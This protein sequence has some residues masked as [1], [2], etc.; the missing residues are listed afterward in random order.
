MEEKNVDQI[1]T[2]F[3]SPTG[4]EV[5]GVTPLREAM[6]R[7]L[8]GTALCA[9]TLNFLMLNYIL[10]I[11][12]VVLLLQ[13]LRGLRGENKWFRV[14]WALMVFRAAV[15]FWSILLYATIYGNLLDGSPVSIAINLFGFAVQFLMIIYIRKGVG[16][17]Q[18]KV[19]MP[20]Q[21][22]SITALLVWYFVF[23]CLALVEYSGWF[24][25]LVMFGTFI[26]IMRSLYRLTEEMEQSKYDIHVQ[27]ASVFDKKIKKWI[28]VALVGAIALGYIFLGSYP[29]D[30]QKA[31]GVLS[32][33][34]EEIK[35]DLLALGYPENALKDLSEEDILACKGAKS[36]VYTTRVEPVNEGRK[37]EEREGTSVSSR[38]VYDE[39]ELNFTDVAVELPDEV[40]QYRIFH[41]FLWMVDPGFNGTEALEIWPAYQNEEGWA[42]RGELTGRVLFNEKGT[43][44]VAPFYT[45]TE[46]SEHR[47]DVFLGV[48]SNRSI[49]ASFSLP[50]GVEMQRGY[51]SYGIETMEEGYMVS[52]WVNYTHQKS[53]LQY[54]VRTAQEVRKTQLWNDPYPFITVQGALQFYRRD[55]RIV[56]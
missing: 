35:S 9:I 3:E 12:G 16:A 41:H 30:W 56:F 29:M 31:E 6:D 47:R 36:I 20:V 17:V 5:Q 21:T 1:S 19:D 26:A 18:Q 43:A 15:Y 33:E 27:E 8:V 39:K 40:T 34:A 51:I 25:A 24:L 45:L 42:A 28:S 37:V 49:F 4:G 14:C 10:P 7:I 52:S 38:T 53:K 13:G 32:A 22:E 23:I 54:P 44:Y 2:V 11:I 46:G 55:G 48:Q 50:N